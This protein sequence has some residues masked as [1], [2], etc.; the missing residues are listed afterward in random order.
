MIR[1]L[2]VGVDG[3]ATKCTVRLEDEEGRLLGREIGGA[4]SM[5]F[6][7]EQVWQTILSALNKI[8]QQ[9]SLSLTNNNIHFHA[10]MGIAGSEIST[11]YQAFI[12]TP[13]PFKS[14]VVTSDAHTAC[15][16]AH[17]AND[18]AIIIAGTGTVG[19]QIQQGVATKV[20]GFGFPHDDAGGGAW[21][22]LQAVKK[23]V[24]VLD[25]RVTLSALTQAVMQRFDN[26]AAKLTAWANIANATAFAELA[27]LV[28][29]HSKAK[30]ETACELLSQAAQAIE[31]LASA[32]QR[33]Q[34]HTAKLPLALI[35]GV[36]PFLE[37]YLNKELR[38]RLVSVTA[39]PDAGAIMLIRKANERK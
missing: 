29:E 3:G 6:A 1:N 4:A 32:L 22:G 7:T 31:Q 21:L 37:P 36:A 11:A 5:R 19:Y 14:C 10:G 30:D 28:I 23:T 33:A 17:G 16:G 8:L 34:T 26:D 20:G 2:Y 38:S 12:N 24:Q 18:G 27:P 25:G 35:G 9:Q 15:L 39:P 13:H